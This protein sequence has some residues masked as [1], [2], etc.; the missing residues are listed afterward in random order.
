MSGHAVTPETPEAPPADRAA[1]MR[2]RK[3]TRERL[4]AER[5]A[6][7][8]AQRR[9]DAEAIARH[10]SQLLGDLRGRTV[11][12]YWPFRGEPNLRAWMAQAH[13]A[14]ARC[15]LPE[16]VAPRTPLR[17]RAWWPGAR[18]VAGVWHIPQP[19]DGAEL[20][21]DVVVAPI[22]GFDA[23]GY[24]LGYGGGFYD[25]TLAATERRPFV[26]GV[27]SAR[28]QLETIHPLPHDVPMDVVVTEHGPVV[29]R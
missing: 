7:P 15:A 27:G 9:A 26:V 14:G 8:A 28:W 29:R 11:A 24:R 4:L 13:A 5:L 23:A 19:A 17:F 1:V 18:M 10:L 20:Q 6:M 25:R 22:V 3:A 12:V 21:P 2:W 16:V